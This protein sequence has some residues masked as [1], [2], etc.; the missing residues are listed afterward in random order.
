MKE[1]RSMKRATIG[2]IAAALALSAC[3]GGTQSTVTP[4]TQMQVPAQSAS[5]AENAV[6]PDRKHHKEKL[7]RLEFTLRVPHKHERRGDRRSPAF[8][9]P[10]TASVKITLL[11]VNGAAPPSGLTTVKTTNLTSATCGGGNGCNVTGPASPV[12]SDSFSVT[13]YDA[14][15]AGG[16]A[17]STATQT[18]VLRRGVANTGS[19]TLLGV[20]STFT[21]TGV[22]AGT[23]GTTIASTPLTLTVKD[24]AGDAI[25]G[26]Y[27]N[28]VTIAA[29]DPSGATALIL[30]SQASSASVISTASTDTLSFFY[31]GEAI[32]SPSLSVTATGAT[33]LTVPFTVTSSVPT[34]TCNGATPAPVPADM[35]ECGTGNEI[36][37]YAT[38]GTGSNASFTAAQPGWGALANVFTQTNTCSAIATVSTPDGI[39]F[40]VTALN[41]AVA[42]T[43]AVT[44][45]GGAQKHADETVT[46]T[47]SSIGVNGRH[48]G[49]KPVRKP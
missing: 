15:N 40:T 5:V 24:A 29:L 39:N 38:S 18:F 12:G 32:V 17:L 47:T 4:A 28:P 13:I 20:P 35:S 27:A 49:A 26:T 3:S 42:G 21:L 14:A 19:L 25:T 30:D 1:T 31:S 46:F 23:A 6:S 44:V 33:G 2:V 34:F 11:T 9:P 16:H 10:S 48:H 7:A 37:L 41:A 8:I 36:D 43:C 22:P 45:T